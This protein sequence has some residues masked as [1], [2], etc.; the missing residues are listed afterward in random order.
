VWETVLRLHTV[1]WL[2][3]KPPLSVTAQSA[4]T[5]APPPTCVRSKKANTRP[6][7]YSLPVLLWFFKLQGF[8]LEII[9]AGVR[10]RQ[11][12]LVIF[13]FLAELLMLE[14]HIVQLEI[15]IL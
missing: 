14:L 1:I 12:T 9:D 4:A 5:L 13:H 7:L 15:H 10:I 8:A 3:L 2:G 6:S 11:L